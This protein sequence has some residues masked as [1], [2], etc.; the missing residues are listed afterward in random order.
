[1]E[2]Y[3]L[4]IK[5]DYLLITGNGSRKD[6]VQF[7]HSIDLLNKLAQHH[8]L[9]K[10]LADYMKVSFDFEPSMALKQ[11]KELHIEPI[12]NTLK[13]ASIINEE[14]LDLKHIWELACK[15]KGIHTKVFIDPDK[16]KAWLNSLN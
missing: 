1:M 12:D 16:A 5:D 4:T 8:G 11:I 15:K 9:D 3:T 7:I 14:M 13:I 2:P 6:V 10:M